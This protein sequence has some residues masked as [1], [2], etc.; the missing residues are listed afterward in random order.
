MQALEDEFYV[1]HLESW[2]DT[3]V[4]ALGDRTPRQASR[5]ASGREQLE[6]LLVSFARHEGTGNAVRRQALANL[7]RRLRLR[8]TGP[9]G[10][11]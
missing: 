7:R 11:G 9:A 4:P 2:V 5:S 8:P 10:E 1:R 6:A 3:P